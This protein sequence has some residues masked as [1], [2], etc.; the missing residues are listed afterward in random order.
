MNLAHRVRK[1]SIGIPLLLAAFAVTPTAFAEETPSLR[2][3]S[4]NRCGPQ[5]IPVQ[6]WLRR[7][8]NAPGEQV[9]SG[10]GIVLVLKSPKG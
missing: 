5:T 3:P 1:L 9:E 8:Y 2:S 6:D 7:W 4:R 10:K